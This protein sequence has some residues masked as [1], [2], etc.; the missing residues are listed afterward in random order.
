MLSKPS[1]EQIRDFIESQSRLE[2]TYPSVGATKHGESP[3]G[4][5]VDRTRIQLGVGQ[6]TFE[7]AQ[8]A[9][10]EWQHYRFDW[11]ELHRPD[12]IPAPD[13]TGHHRDSVERER[14]GN[15]EQKF[16]VF[17]TSPH[18]RRILWNLI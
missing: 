18:D 9:L 5:D 11:V 8:L 4:F 7:V 3:V 14:L 16:A 17:V 10:C 12:T 13:Q 15:R 6:A 1:D 2:F